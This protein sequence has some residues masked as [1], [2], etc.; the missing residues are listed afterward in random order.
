MAQEQTQGG[1][2]GG[3]LDA[4]MEAKIKERV[5]KQKFKAN[6]LAHG[7]SEADYKTFNTLRSHLTALVE[8]GGCSAAIAVNTDHLA[9]AVYAVATATYLDKVARFMYGVLDSC[10]LNPN[11]YDMQKDP[12]EFY[13]VLAEKKAEAQMVIDKHEFAKTIK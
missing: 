2:M 1:I 10:G 8:C 12:T 11:D 4:L 5:E 7:Y 13:Q 6:M 3:L 9:S